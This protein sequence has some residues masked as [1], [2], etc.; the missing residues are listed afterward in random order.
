MKVKR[1]NTQ[2]NQQLPIIGITTYHRNELG[3]FHLPGAYIEAVEHANGIPVLLPPTSGDLR[4]LLDRLDSLIFS[5]G[6]DIDPALYNSPGH[7]SIYLVDPERDRFELALARVALTLDLPIL[8]ICRGM[9]L[10]NVATGGDL[11]SHVP[12]QYGD[13]QF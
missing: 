12:E 13:R 8:G 3:D 4:S 2:V 1:L 6:G 5:G 7:P 11:I 10:L 9:Q